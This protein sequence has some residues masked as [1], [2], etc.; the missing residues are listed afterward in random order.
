MSYTLPL[1][2]D[3]TARLSSEAAEA[4]LKLALTSEQYTE[5]LV[6]PE[7]LRL[8]LYGEIMTY[9][10]ASDQIS[11]FYE[12]LEQKL[13]KKLEPTVDEKLTNA[14]VKLG[15]TW[16]KSLPSLDGWNL[17]GKIR[18]W[19][20]ATGFQE[21]NQWFVNLGSRHSNLVMSR[22]DAFL[23]GRGITFIC[24]MMTLSM[25]QPSELQ[26]TEWTSACRDV[27]DLL[28]LLQLEPLIKW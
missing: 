26:V 2:D 10:P 9:G 1:S 11:K 8:S 25:F 12:K 20:E 6:L 24:W 7:T 14:L 4:S 13:D 27:D 22:N 5:I 23:C 3:R 16:Q 21:L 19:S 28:A 18:N 17:R 15:G